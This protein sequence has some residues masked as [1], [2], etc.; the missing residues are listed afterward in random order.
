MVTLM[1]QWPAEAIARAGLTGIEFG[2]K[3]QLQSVQPAHYITPAST[4]QASCA[5]P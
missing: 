3:D 4:L 2:D 5:A 1:Y